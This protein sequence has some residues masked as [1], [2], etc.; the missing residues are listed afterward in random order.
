MIGSALLCTDHLICY[1][2]I[3]GTDT[4]DECGTSYMSCGVVPQSDL[5]HDSD[6]V[7]DSYVKGVMLEFTKR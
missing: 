5:I 2:C 7:R 3:C 6:G 1:G 4:E